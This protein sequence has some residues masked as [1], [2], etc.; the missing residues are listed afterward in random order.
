MGGVSWSP[1]SLPPPS[2]SP[3]AG[4]PAQPAGW[5]DDPWDGRRRRYWDGA[6]W[7]GYTDD[8]Y[9]QPSW[10]GEDP[11]AL[12]T[13]NRGVARWLGISVFV[14]PFLQAFSYWASITAF[15]D[16]L[17][18]LEEL[19]GGSSPS[20]FGATGGGWVQ[21]GQLLSTL[22]LVVLVLRMVWL[23][24]ASRAAQALG[25]PLRREPGLACAGW[26]IPIVNFWWPYQGM[27]S[28]FPPDDP[29]RARVARWWTCY[30]V[31]TLGGVVGA[32]FTI[33]LPPAG[34]AVALALPALIGVLGAVQERQLVQEVQ[35]RQ[36]AEAGVGVVG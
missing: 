18:R 32:L 35:R 8:L 36:A 26:I 27:A 23:Y 30:L 34:D 22:S 19:D 1:P 10:N 17:N 31:A 13:G 21:A 5:Y 9:D 6:A 15:R 3:P 14:T 29:M 7:T 25:H 4:P 20:P 24:R 12:V 2:S 28:L 33:P 16:A 11:A